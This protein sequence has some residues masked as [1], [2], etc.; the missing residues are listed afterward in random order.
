M[1]RK[2]RVALLIGAMLATMV[3]TASVAA[4]PGSGCGMIITQSTTLTADIGPCGRGGIVIAADGIS[5][6]LGGHTI[7]G[8]GSTGDGVGILFD[9]VTD[10]RVSNGTVRGFDAGVAI[11]GGS[12][13]E[14]IRLT[15]RDNIGSLKASRPAY[16][17]G[18]VI[19]SSSSN[20]IFQNT[21]TNN[22]P[23]GGVSIIANA[24]TASDSNAI[25][26]NTIIDNDVDRASVNENDGVRVEGPNATGTVIMNNTIIANGRDGIAVFDDQGTGF[27]NAGLYIR[28]NVVHGNGF[29]GMGNRK[30][31]G[32]FVGDGADRGFI[33]ENE[34][35]GNAANGIRV[36]SVDGELFVNTA[37]GNVRYP[38]VVDAFDLK[39]ENPGC[40]DNEWNSN[41]FGTANQTC[42]A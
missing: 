11:V 41:T 35:T 34:V 30:G 21:V 9:G 6:D 19:Q 32:I 36:G 29:H 18:I 22:G 42:I 5:V 1:Q 24:T 20:W 17:D 3:A 2:S 39:D 25:D 12:A 10:V 31:D 38:G 28:D 40:A 37:T 13:N 4:A 8:K 14:V 26:R 7:T 27:P 33:F 16:G 15:I 23:F